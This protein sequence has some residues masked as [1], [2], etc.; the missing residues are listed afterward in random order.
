M[1]FRCIHTHIYSLAARRGRF[2]FQ[3][4]DPDRAARRTEARKSRAEA[5][6]AEKSRN[7][8]SPTGDLLKGLR[9]EVTRRDSV[10]LPEGRQPRDLGD[11]IR[12]DTKILDALPGEDGSEKY[13][14]IRVK[15]EKIVKRVFEKRYA[16]DLAKRP[17]AD[18]YKNIINEIP[19]FILMKATTENGSE[20]EML[21]RLEKELLKLRDRAKD[22]SLFEEAWHYLKD[23]IGWIRGKPTWTLEGDNRFLE[24]QNLPIKPRHKTNITF[25]LQRLEKHYRDR[26]EKAHGHWYGDK[27]DNKKVAFL[28]EVELPFF[29]E[30]YLNKAILK[31]SSPEQ[32]VH[33][34]SEVIKRKF[35]NTLKEEQKEAEQLVADQ[36]EIL[37]RENDP[38]WVKLRT[39][40]RFHTAR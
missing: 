6:K 29:R 7:I 10:N 14:G 26:L 1:L 4:E 38:D 31:G 16:E 3:E 30:Y 20:V 15:M 37:T 39:A 27:Y 32:L 9:D 24:G 8:A 23:F 11:S 34:Y 21:T 18:Q 17:F 13:H 28:E 40:V 5:R 12:W 2:L 33:D 22:D 25:E 35:R 36:A 19:E